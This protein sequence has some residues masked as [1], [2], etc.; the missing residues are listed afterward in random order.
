MA[1]KFSVGTYSEAVKH[2]RTEK[3]SVANTQNETR[4]WL[5]YAMAVR[6]SSG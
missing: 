6:T 5:P 3:H 4:V 2:S 1:T